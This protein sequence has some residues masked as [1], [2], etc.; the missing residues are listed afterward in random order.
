MGEKTS[1]AGR[2][3][4]ASTAIISNHI[5][6]DVRDNFGKGYARRLRA[7]GKIPAVLYGH[8]TEPQHLALPGHETAL[9]LRKANAILELEIDGKTQT[10]LVKD[11]QKDPVRQIIE[12]IDLIVIRKGEK[13][14][15]D[16]AVHVVGES[17][18]GTS[19]DVDAHSLLVEASAISIPE[20]L[21]V[22]IE[23]LEIG[24]TIHASDVKLPEGVTLIVDPETLVLAVHGEV[25]Q[26]LGDESDQEAAAEESA[27]EESAE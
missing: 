15:V 8:G 10:G 4:A 7:A 13:V 9:L 23:G 26:D 20:Y 1:R 22:S 6:A 17:A 11:V 21:E 19:V 16:V 5:V 2:P 18:P 24:A 14:E 12:H 25:E 27:A 3:S